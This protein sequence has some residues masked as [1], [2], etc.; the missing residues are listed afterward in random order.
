MRMLDFDWPSLYNICEIS[1]QDFSRV[2]EKPKKEKKCLD[3][4]TLLWENSMLT[5]FLCITVKCDAYT[6]HICSA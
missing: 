5:P 4:W 3:K 6:S 1:L 2:R